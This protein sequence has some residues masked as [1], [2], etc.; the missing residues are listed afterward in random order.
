MCMCT[1][2]DFNF[3]LIQLT[4]I[5]STKLNIKVIRA[6]VVKMFDDDDDDDGKVCNCM[7]SLKRRVC[8]HLLSEEMFAE[9]SEKLSSHQV[10][11][12]RN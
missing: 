3:L 11:F 7:Q 1:G 6:I 12:C 2:R 5:F 10:N 4:K 8:Y 9:I